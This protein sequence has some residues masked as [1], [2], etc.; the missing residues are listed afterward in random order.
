MFFRVPL[1]GQLKE[2]GWMNLG[3]LPPGNF[4]T[5]LVQGRGHLQKWNQM[6][7]DLLI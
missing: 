2:I 6:M 7:M 1:L 4:L 3:R 5:L